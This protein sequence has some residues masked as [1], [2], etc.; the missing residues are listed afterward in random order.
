[1]T[2]DG[3]TPMVLCAYAKVSRE[4]LYAPACWAVITWSK[5]TPTRSMFRA[6]RSSLVLEMM[7]IS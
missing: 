4:G 5:S 2:W 7:A 3:S 1:M 6:I